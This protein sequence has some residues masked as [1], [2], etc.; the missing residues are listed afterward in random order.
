M[1]KDYWFDITYKFSGR[2]MVAANSEE[3]A[4]KYAKE[5]C[6][7]VLGSKPHSNLPENEFSWQF[8]VHAEKV[9]DGISL[10]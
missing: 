7:L 2:I 6:G 3:Q 8:P 9:I 10:I 5:N 4:L 1:K